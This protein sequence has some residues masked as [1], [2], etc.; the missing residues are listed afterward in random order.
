MIDM[1]SAAKAAKEAKRVRELFREVFDNDEAREALA[2]LG[3]YFD[4]H[5]PSMPTVEFDP[6]QAAYKDGHKAVFVEIQDI[7][8]GKYEENL[9]DLT[10]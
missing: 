3:N 2:I 7:L 4:T 6:T 10:I 1:E 9:E 5:L 8:K